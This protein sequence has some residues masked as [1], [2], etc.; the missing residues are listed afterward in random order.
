MRKHV[1]RIAALAALVAAVAI[2]A[3]TSS[4]SLST[5]YTVAFNAPNGLPANVDRLVADAG[6]TITARIP[7]VG[8]IGVYSTNPNF[9]A[10]MG[11]NS[12]VKAVDASLTMS[13]PEAN[14][15]PIAMDADNNAGTYSP[16]GPDC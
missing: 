1:L 12:S 2:P 4:S 15:G 6:G 14:A 5:F 3:A 7:E 11:A 13:T 9:V 10:A 16:T 8:G